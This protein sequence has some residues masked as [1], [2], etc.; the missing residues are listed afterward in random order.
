MF[1]NISPLKNKSEVSQR[2][3]VFDGQAGISVDEACRFLLNRWLEKQMQSKRKLT[4]NSEI[5]EKEKDSHASSGNG[6]LKKNVWEVQEL[7]GQLSRF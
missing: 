2:F 4:S 6:L 3:Y 1:G 7:L 5:S